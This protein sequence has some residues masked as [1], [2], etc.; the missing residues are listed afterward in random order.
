[1]NSP[2]SEP[3]ISS[4]RMAVSRTVRDS[5]PCVDWELVASLAKGAKLSRP[6]DGF[7]PTNPQMLAG[8]RIEPP[9]SLAEAMGTMP[10]A[11]IAADPLEDPPEMNSRF[12]GLC[13]CPFNSDSL[14]KV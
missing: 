7:S 12:Q 4:N 5:T 1:M 13:V 11:T 9:P 8:M 2:T 10:A 6:R 14:A 3:E